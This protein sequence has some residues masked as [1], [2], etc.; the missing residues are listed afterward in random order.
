[1]THTAKSTSTS[2]FIFHLSDPLEAKEKA[3]IV[4]QKVEEFGFALIRGLFDREE[5]RSKIPLI[6]D[7]LSTLNLLPSS[8]VP[9]DAIRKNNAK[10]SIGS[11]SGSQTGISRLMITIINPMY[12][13]DILGLRDTFR[14]LVILRDALAMRENTLFDEV[15]QKPKFNGTRLQLYPS[16]GG[17]MTSHI[18]KR[19][20]ENVSDISAT[21]IQLVMLL[22]EKGLDYSSGG[23]FVEK[24][25]KFIDSEDGS[26]SGDVLVYSGST[27]HGVADIDSTLAFDPLNRIGRV[28]ALA[29][30]YN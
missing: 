13:A 21:Y 22:T 28:V 8:G 20:I 2:T 30:I 18:D 29:T 24:N 12:D 11:Q 25:G 7:T 10:W 6:K 14:K 1:M 23:A 5:I 3:G 9:A 27:M 26:L 16:G 19:A 4:A 17:F 15:L